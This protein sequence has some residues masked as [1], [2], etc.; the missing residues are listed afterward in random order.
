MTKPEMDILMKK[1]FSIINKTRDAGQAE[2]ARADE[3]VFAN[4]RRVGSYTGQPKE[5]VLMTY[6]MKH[7][8]GIA[9]YINGH[10]SQREDVTGRITDAIVYLC[11]LWGMVDEGK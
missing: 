4:F 7:I 9:S 3:D 2:Y 6:F 5:A 1:I 8:D 11:L 10:T